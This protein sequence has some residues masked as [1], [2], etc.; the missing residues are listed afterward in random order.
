MAYLLTKK[1]LVAEFR[2][3][4]L[5]QRM[6]RATRMGDPWFHIIRNGQDILVTAESAKQALERLKRGDMPAQFPSREK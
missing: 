5:V 3:I 1:D 4:D 6:L 2:S